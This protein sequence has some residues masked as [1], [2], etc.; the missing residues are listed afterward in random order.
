MSVLTYGIFRPLKYQRARNLGR[1]RYIHLGFLVA[2]VILPLIPTVANWVVGGYGVDVVR[3][4][5]CVPRE[6]LT[7]ENIPIALFGTATLVMLTLIATKIYMLVSTIYSMHGLYCV[8][9]Y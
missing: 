9:V 2:G 1:L 5:S 8:V 6:G 3:S 7:L 4:Y